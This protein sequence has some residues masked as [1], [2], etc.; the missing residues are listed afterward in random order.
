M[1]RYPELY[2]QE[3]QQVENRFPELKFCSMLFEKGWLAYH[4]EITIR[5]S[6]GTS[7]K[8]VLLTYPHLYPANPPTV[9][10]IQ[11]LP[12]EEPHAT[13]IRLMISARHQMNNGALCLVE[14]D[15]FRESSG[16]IRGIDVLRRAGQWYFSI[17]SG[18]NPYDSL[19]ADLQSHLEKLGDILLGPEFYTDELQ[20]GG[21]FYVAQY[22]GR[23]RDTFRLVGLAF[24]SD[25]EQV[26]KFKDCRKTL[27]NCFP[28]INNN[29]WDTAE[30]FATKQND[31]RQ[32]LEERNIFRGFWWDLDKEP[33]PPRSGL[34]ILRLISE[35]D[36][37]ESF[38]KSL[39]SFSSDV[40]IE[41]HLF[42]GLRFPDRKGGYDWLFCCLEL[43]S[44]R[45]K[46][47]L[48]LTSREKLELFK[49]AKVYVLFRHAIRQRELMLRNQGRV[50]KDTS[51][52]TISLFGVGS[53]GSTIADLLA[54]AGVGHL[55]LF[56]YDKMQTGN[57]I[58][59][60]SGIEHFGEFKVDTT[61]WNIV[62]H[63]PFVKV[64]LNKLNLSDSYQTIEAALSESDLVISSTANE[65]LE[66]VV[67]EIA[68][69]KRQPVYYVR[70]M[71]GG[72]AGRIFRV[73]PGRDACRY[74]LSQYINDSANEF[75]QWLKIP[76]IENT[77]LSHECG[78][79]ILAASGVDLTIIS[80]LCS[81][82][83]LEDIEK[84]FEG[85]NHW[86]W[87]SGSI[88][89]HPAL[90]QPY[91]F[92]ARQIPPAPSCPFCSKP[93]IKAIVMP[94]EIQTKIEVLTIQSGQNETGGILVGYFD[95]D[96]NAVVTNASEAGPNAECSPVKFLK[97]IP[98]TQAWLENQIQSSHHSIEYLGEWHSHTNGETTPSITDIT[99]L[100]GITESPNYLCQ[101]PV[102]IILGSTDKG[103]IVKKSAY[104]FS[105]DRP[106]QNIEY[107][108]SN[109]EIWY[110]I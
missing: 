91:T 18:H 24:S 64:S 80:S 13:L 67:N 63:N 34:D 58:R 53:V 65:S 107:K 99:S 32:L 47:A 25:F 4:G 40:S 7:R 108:V 14:Q 94:P 83:V 48:T 37:Q 35:G 97:D 2:R 8:K 88:E 36:N 45:V 57:V 77:L 75:G 11:S 96:K 1:A 106:F 39:N 59:H 9:T 93:P 92:A 42:I 19:E 55:K 30:N 26:I 23:T 21:Y 5:S 110:I 73:I 95:E 85:N 22:P 61:F 72:S 74:C 102:M 79:P 62:Q 44:T 41:S 104:C 12:E 54:K 69:I 109:N 78:N 51:K 90:S 16:I 6:S 66:T 3:R 20:K 76:E 98:Y 52:S 84:N 31:L 89:N 43:R 81:K 10:P 50:P 27:E 70:A 86:L 105:Q 82:V 87:S 60:Q 29:I 68:V 103:E 46:A 71:R 28:W 38:E 49:N 33:T 100:T 17:E 15:P 56:D 101:T